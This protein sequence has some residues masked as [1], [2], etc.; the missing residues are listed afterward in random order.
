MAWDTPRNIVTRFKEMIQVVATISF[1]HIMIHQG[2]AFTRSDLH[3]SFA[4][5]AVHNHLIVVGAN[6]IHLRQLILETDNAPIL[7]EYYENT[8]VSANGTEEVIGNNNRNSSKVTTTSFFSEPTVTADG[9]F[10]GVT[11]IPTSAKDSGGVGILKGGEWVL[12]PNTNYLIRITN[13]SGAAVD[14]GLTL[15]YY[16]PALR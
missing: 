6:P 9:D 12:K 8:T 15:F 7:M 11:L 16:E 10:M 1:D 3:E 13:N 2:K 14:Y 5:L 4:S